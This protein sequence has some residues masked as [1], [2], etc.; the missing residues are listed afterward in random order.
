MIDARQMTLNEAGDWLELANGGG[1]MYRDPAVTVLSKP[2]YTR[3]RQPRRLE[4]V[5]ATPRVEDL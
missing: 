2:Y 1:V 3:H 4:T 5:G